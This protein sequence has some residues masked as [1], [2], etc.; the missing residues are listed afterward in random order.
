MSL[1]SWAGVHPW[2]LA[3]RILSDQSYTNPLPQIQGIIQFQSC[4]ARISLHFQV[5]SSRIKS[6]SW[7][8]N[9]NDLFPWLGQAIL[10]VLTLLCWEVNYPSMCYLPFR[11][12]CW[13]HLCHCNYT[14]SKRL[15]GLRVS[16][17]KAATRQ[18]YRG[19]IK[20]FFCWELMSALSL[21]ETCFP[22]PL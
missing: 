22:L 18:K 11:S 20:H 9:T 6:A 14:A 10:V 16:H 19:K 3:K 1:L 2:N 17:C 15:T 4:Q 8:S 21:V 7:I 5:L 12:H 13:N